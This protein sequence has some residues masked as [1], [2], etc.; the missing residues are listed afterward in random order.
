[1]RIICVFFS[2]QVLNLACSK[3]YFVTYDSGSFECLLK[4]VKSVC[5]F[6]FVILMVCS[7]KLRNQEIHSML[8]IC[9]IFC[10]SH[11]DLVQIGTCHDAINCEDYSLYTSPVSPWFASG[12]VLL[13]IPSTVFE[14]FGS[15]RMHSNRFEISLM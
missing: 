11:S 4:D 2:F 15:L 10:E 6:A 13:H 5:F 1:M 3:L 14:D 7:F 9:I 8:E 12:V